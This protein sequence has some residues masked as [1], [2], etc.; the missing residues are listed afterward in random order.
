MTASP[1]APDTRDLAQRTRAF[2]RDVCLPAEV[3]D[4]SGHGVDP[5]LRAELQ[6]AARSAGLLAPHVAV[7]WGGLGLDMTARV[8]VFEEA[9]YSL[10]GPLALNCAAPDEA[11]MHLLEEVATPEQKEQY[12]RPLVA[13]ET[14]SA[15]AMTEPFPGAGSDPSML[16]T[17]ARRAG[18]GWSIDGEKH[19]ITGA[20]GAA[21]VIC[22]ARTGE[23][24]SR[25]EG[26]TMFLV[27]ADNPGLEIGRL[28]PTIDRGASGGHSELRFRD[29]RVADEAVLGEVGL[30]LRNA[31][32]RL[33]PARLGHCMRWLGIARRSL[34]TAL[35]Y[36]AEREAFGQR[37]EELGMVQALLADCV[38]DIESSHATIVW[39]CG[40]LDDGE[41]GTHES[42]VAKVHVSEAVWRVVDRCVQ[43]CGGLGITRDLPLAR[44]LNEV[45]PFR[46]YDGPTETHRWSIARRASRRRA[47][48]R[49]AI[50]NRP[51]QR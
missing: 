18:A 12:L 35:D 32:V 8:D 9:G 23:A 22:L 15:F 49:L 7:E 45:R 19:F 2:V 34:D 44:F 37:L 41:R 21:F 30:G 27:D 48:E 31:Q 29:C 39:A 42:S 1:P 36:A 5:E 6:E 11:N 28:M 14:R 40:L 16:R 17:T 33:A 3:R 38:V 46:I 13:G 4:T 24:L 20:E 10:L 51:P 47:Q 50:P 43:I 25:G 26:A